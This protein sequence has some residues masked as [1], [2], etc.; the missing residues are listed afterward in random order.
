MIFP[1][2]K[3]LMAKLDA[4]Y[5]NTANKIKVLQTIRGS[6]AVSRA[7]LA[8]LTGLSAPTITRIVESLITTGGLVQ[9]IGTGSSESGRPPN[10]VRFSGSDKYVVGIDLGTTHIDGVVANL[11]AELVTEMRIPALVEAGY[12][13]V[14]ERT[15]ALVRDLI[16][17]SGVPMNRVLGVG[18]AVAGLVD[19]ERNVVEY[20][21]DFGWRDADV[22]AD[23]QRSVPFPVVFDNVSRVMALG[24]RA[25]GSGR[26][27]DTFICI[28]VGYGIGAGIITNGLPYAGAHGMSGEFGHIVVDPH[29]DA[30]CMCGNRGCLEALASGRGISMAAQQRLAAGTPS[31]LASDY[32][33][34]PSSITARA[35]AQAAGSGDELCAQVMGSAARY[36][37]LGIVTLVNLFDPSLIVIGGGVASAGERFLEVVRSTVADRSLSR[38]ARNLE[39]VPSSFG[40]KAA[41]LGAVS[42]IL[43]RVLSLESRFIAALQER[44]DRAGS[45]VISCAGRAHR[46]SC[47]PMASPG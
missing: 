30:R 18:M 26:E 34:D 3:K 25:F 4:T 14:I 23:M 8:K 33:S 28:N 20:S 38:H 7:D 32:R 9:D 40:A 46:I 16:D 41:V 10:L 44:A 37:G 42:L 15:S 47:T 21:P 22:V 11:D 17:A 13:A 5:I 27:T 43:E 19:L 31:M 2:G 1:N 12:E 36:L 45:C 35:V 24:E 29:S 6:D 39:I